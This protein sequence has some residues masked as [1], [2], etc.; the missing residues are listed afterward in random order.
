M[1]IYYHRFNNVS[2]GSLSEKAEQ[3]TFFQ[4]MPYALREE[5]VKALHIEDYPSQQIS[6][7]FLCGGA[8][9]SSEGTVPIPYVR[10][11]LESLSP[12]CCCI[13]NKCSLLCVF[14]LLCL[15]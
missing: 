4:Q 3:F 13:L 2:L 6:T 11:S 1:H 14:V 7:L 8:Y 10:V 5:I 9:I 12:S 15:I